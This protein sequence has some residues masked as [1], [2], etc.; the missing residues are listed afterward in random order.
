MRRGLDCSHTWKALL[1][2]D[3]RRSDRTGR[4]KGSQRLKLDGVPDALKWRLGRFHSAI[5]P[6]ESRDEKR[7]WDLRRGSGRSAKPAGQKRRREVVAS[8]NP[9]HH[10]G[11]PAPR[12]RSLEPVKAA[13]VRFSVHKI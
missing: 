6:S 12:L 3:M 1:S 10:A 5:L 11:V 7:Q 2:P 9:A 4:S 13:A 8:W